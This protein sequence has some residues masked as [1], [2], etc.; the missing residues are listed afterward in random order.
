ME[1]N[2]KL[3]KLELVKVPVL[4]QFCD[5]CIFRIGGKKTECVLPKIPDE[6]KEKIIVRMF[7]KRC[8]DVSK[9]S[10]LTHSEDDVPTNYIFLYSRY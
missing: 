8:S 6:T 9:L 7:G 2:F 3:E 4:F 5:G 1:T 10:C